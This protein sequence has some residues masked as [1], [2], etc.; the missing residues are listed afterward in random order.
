MRHVGRFSIGAAASSSR[1]S[2]GPQW[3]SGPATC[4]TRAGTTSCGTSPRCSTCRRARSLV[5]VEERRFDPLTP[6]VV[7]TAVGEEQVDYLYEH[8]AE[9]PGVKIVQIYLRDYE[10]GSLAAQILGYTGEISPEELKQLRKD[11]RYR[12][13]DRI[14]KTGIEAAYDSY[15]RGRPGLAP[16]PCGLPRPAASPVELA[17]GID[18]RLRAPADAR[19]APPAR[20][21][22]R[23]QVRHRSRASERPVGGGRRRDRRARPERRGVSSRWRRRRP[24]S[25]PCSS[26][27]PMRR[28]S[29]RCTRTRA[30]RSSTARPRASIRRAPPGS[31]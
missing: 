17:A 13:G 9:F 31:R 2:P 8:Q 10:Y 11:G 5:Q 21:R 28:S 6:V 27:R 7:K 14:G 29:K 26:G 4:Q 25:R 24:S 15:L 20:R 23:A 18:T 22:G 1:T 30:I 12:A 16:D 3:S 19:H